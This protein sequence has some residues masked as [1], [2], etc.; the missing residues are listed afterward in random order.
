MDGGGA[1]VANW[2][3]LETLYDLCILLPRIPLCMMGV[4]SYFL[5]HLFIL[6]LVDSPI[7]IIPQAS[8]HP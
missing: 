7:E 1:E 4:L 8:R 5:H 3:T 6:N 2:M